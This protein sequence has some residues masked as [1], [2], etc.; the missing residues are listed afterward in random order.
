MMLFVT[1]AL[2]RDM[3]SRIDV[4]ESVVGT[5]EEIVARMLPVS[6]A[7]NAVFTERHLNNGLLLGGI[8]SSSSSGRADSARNAHNRIPDKRLAEAEAAMPC[9]EWQRR[10]LAG[11]RP[12]T[13]LAAF[14]EELDSNL[15]LLRDR[16]LL[17]ARLDAAIDMHLIPRY[18]KEHGAEL[19]RSRW[20][21]GTQWFE[22][23]FT[24]QSVTPEARLTL[25]ALPMPALE[26]NADY[27]RKLITIC[28]GHGI[29]IGVLMADREFFDTSVMRVMTDEGID[30]L[31]P[32]RNTPT[33]VE[34]IGRF[35]AGMR[36]SR[37]TV[38]IS[39]GKDRVQY[40]GVIVERKKSAAAHCD[41]TDLPPHERYI[42]FATNN[43]DLDVEEY[44]RRWGIETGYR[45]I[46]HARPK[47]RSKNA[48]LRAFCFLYGIMLF[49][50]WVM[51]NILHAAQNAPDHQN[52]D[53]TPVITQDEMT[54]YILLHI[55]AHMLPPRPPKP[56]P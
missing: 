6:H 44:A 20:K 50:A 4:Y 7:P 23:Y 47:T 55:L 16:G 13:A 53:G 41:D 1:T 19:H 28:R 56:P 3:T 36:G 46:E 26:D 43:P 35:A 10:H 51:F 27:L 49:N 34:E 31:I 18:D 2:E 48:E 9:G 21:N 8:F 17:P 54:M 33:V 52:W 12:G 5:M 37:S 14:R 25:G 15:D 24:I 11:I 40:T 39:D 42:M 29:V 38:T 30:Y 22:R 45:M 32:C